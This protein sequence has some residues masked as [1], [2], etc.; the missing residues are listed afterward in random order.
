MLL[1]IEKIEDNLV[2][3]IPSAFAHRCGF[4]DGAEVNMRLKND[5]IVIESADQSFSSLMNCWSEM[6]DEEPRSEMFYG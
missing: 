6:N 5:H 4:D 1:K 3:Q 2:V